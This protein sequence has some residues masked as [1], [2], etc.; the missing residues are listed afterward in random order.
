MNF[1]LLGK[2]LFFKHNDLGY[3][4]IA[5]LYRN[6]TVEENHNLSLLVSEPAE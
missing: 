3:K 5:D 6:L 4:H 2:T 1:A